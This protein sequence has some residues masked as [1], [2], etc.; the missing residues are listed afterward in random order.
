MPSKAR[1]AV[2]AA[3]R[4]ASKADT[5]PVW[6]LLGTDPFLKKDWLLRYRAA[7]REQ[8]GACD[9]LSY[10]K[11]D[12]ALQPAALFD[13]LRTGS[14][15]GGFKVICVD[16]ADEL[17]RRHAQLL[18]SYMRAPAP[19][20]ALVLSLAEPPADKALAKA[21]KAA[22]S[23]VQL[24]P[25]RRGELVRWIID[26]CKQHGK[27]IDSAAAAALAE[28]L[29][30][31]P[32]ML[33]G[34]LRQLAQQIGARPRIGVADVESAVQDDRERARYELS[35]AIARAN[36]RSALAALHSLL[37]RDTPNEVYR[38]TIPYL[39]NYV[40]QIKVIAG[41]TAQGHSPAAIQQTLGRRNAYF[42]VKE[43]GLLPS[44][45]VDRFAELL[46][47][48]DYQLKTSAGSETTL[49]ETLI[50]SLCSGPRRQPGSGRRYR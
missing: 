21:A 18:L 31:K 3:P 8:H 47:R 32:G 45:E 10:G 40:A 39:A 30:E 28:R 46:A 34:S 23:V 11:E 26:R 17:V 7:R 38:S 2:R 36:A 20:A 48:T 33:D 35:A 43:A 9:L 15:F 13:E 44:R 42:L 24:A 22:H 41:M 16:P 12:G 4:N 5:S 1:K 14:L 27:Q 37:L 50:I 19:N 25:P 6:F 49:L 29:G